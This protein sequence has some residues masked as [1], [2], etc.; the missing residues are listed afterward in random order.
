MIPLA[1]VKCGGVFHK[2]ILAAIEKVVRLMI[3]IDSR[4]LW[5][6]I[7]RETDGNMPQPPFGGMSGMNR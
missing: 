3:I 4:E 2:N 5:R 7:P 6:E 1:L